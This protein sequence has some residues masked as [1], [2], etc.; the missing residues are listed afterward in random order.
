MC[1]SNFR[2]GRVNF[3]HCWLLLIH[4]VGRAMEIQ[5]QRHP[6][7]LSSS[8]SVSPEPP[9]LVKM[10]QSG[11]GDGMDSAFQP[12]NFVSPAASG[13]FP[14]Q[15]G[16]KDGETGK[17]TSLSKT[18]LQSLFT[19]QLQEEN[20][21]LPWNVTVILWVS[22]YWRV[23]CLTRDDVVLGKIGGEIVENTLGSG[24]NTALPYW[25]VVLYL[26]PKQVGEAINSG[27]SVDGT[28]CTPGIIF[29]FPSP[30]LDHLQEEEG[31]VDRQVLVP[32][33]SSNFWELSMACLF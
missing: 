10:R 9:D 31:E 12:A 16:S 24:F 27:D 21:P 25:F 28:P 14:S 5:K 6:K 17:L 8:S 20:I 18:A 11:I 4:P 1:C 15:E 2:E 7:H 22:D 29:D 3:L 32:N 33:L 30:P 19:F 26:G 13:T 23:T